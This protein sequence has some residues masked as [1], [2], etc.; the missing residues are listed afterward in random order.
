MKYIGYGV[1]ADTAEIEVYECECGYHQGVDATFLAQ[2]GP[3]TITCP[4]C[5][6]VVII[7]DRQDATPVLT[8]T[9]ERP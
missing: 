3:A 5:K 7:N 8:N 4:S 9:E 6:Q 1:V 2:V